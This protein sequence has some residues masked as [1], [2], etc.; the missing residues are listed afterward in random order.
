MAHRYFE[1]KVHAM[2]YAKYR[3]VPPSALIQRMISF[4]KEKYKGPLDLAYDVGCGSGQSTGFLAPYFKRVVGTDI[5]ASQI[6][7]A[8]NKSTDK[9]VTYIVSPAE[10]IPEK[11]K[12]VQMISVSQAAHWFDL[13]KFYDEGKR[14]L[15]P[16]GVCCLYGYEFPRFRWDKDPSLNSSL[17][18]A[19]DQLYDGDLRGYWAAERKIVDNRYKEFS[20]PYNDFTRDDTLYHEMP[21]SVSDIVN[22]CFT[23][24]GYQNFVKQHGE[25]EGI[26]LLAKFQD[27]VMTVLDVSTS[28]EDT[29][30]T[31]RTS[32]FLL[33]ARV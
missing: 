4:L 16:G 19:L 22:Y 18:E 21:T 3:T 12:T 33:M 9:N 11:D 25:N 23:W 14:V 2:L 26:K 13:P 7:Q 27:R 29:M 10:N 24:S 20:I 30:L 17:D 31:R 15:T 28:P 32:F 1:G 5:S 6:E 8:E